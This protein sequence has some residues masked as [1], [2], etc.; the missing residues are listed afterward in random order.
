MLSISYAI[1]EVSELCKPAQTFKTCT[2]QKGR[3]VLPL[4]EDD[5]V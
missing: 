5:G 3:Y 1:F 4:L 2:Q